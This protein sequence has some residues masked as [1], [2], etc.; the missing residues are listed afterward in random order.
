[1]KRPTYAKLRARRVRNLAIMSMVCTV[2]S[3][4]FLFAGAIFAEGGN[5]FEALLMWFACAGA[6]F[7]SAGF[8]I[9]ATDEA[10]S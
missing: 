2:A 6:F 5:R 10:S 4:M 8:I 9:L 1:M 7:G 3:V